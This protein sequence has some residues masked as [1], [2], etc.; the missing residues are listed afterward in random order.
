MYSLS[1]KTVS[2]AVECTHINV[3]LHLRKHMQLKD[4]HVHE[5]SNL[6]R[7]KD[8]IT[9]TLPPHGNNKKASNYNRKENE[10]TV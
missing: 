2:V 9:A 8:S 4:Q 6:K 5:K 1:N 7:F 3:P 10:A